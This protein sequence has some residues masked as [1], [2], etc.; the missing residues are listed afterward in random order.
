MRYQNGDRAYIVAAKNIR[1]KER[2]NYETT[3]LKN[4]MAYG[5]GLPRGFDWVLRRRI[6]QDRWV[7]S[8]EDD[9]DFDE[10]IAQQQTGADKQ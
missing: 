1:T 9:E 2:S 4:A 6:W 8:F 3:N 7:P 10:A 5:H